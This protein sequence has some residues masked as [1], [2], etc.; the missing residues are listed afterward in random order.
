MG[1]NT[2]CARGADSAGSD[3][4]CAHDVAALAPL[5]GGTDHLGIQE[6]NFGGRDEKETMNMIWIEHE[7]L[8]MTLGAT[9]KAT[10][11]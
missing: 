5:W 11:P 2:R 1:G 7:S 6:H 4:R 8:N 10:E 9:W 3:V